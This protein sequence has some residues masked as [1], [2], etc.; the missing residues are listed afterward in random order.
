M[1][2]GKE[3]AGSLVIARGNSTE[4]LE[5]AKEILDPVTCLV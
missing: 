3:V 2:G 5:F 4:L 1:N